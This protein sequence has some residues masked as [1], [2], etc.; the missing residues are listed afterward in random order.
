MQINDWPQFIAIVATFLATIGSLLYNILMER[1]GRV[2]NIVVSRR[3]ERIETIMKSSAHVMALAHPLVI[4]TKEQTF[5]VELMRHFEMAN[6]TLQNCKAIDIEIKAELKSV[7]EE[8][9]KY[10]KL[11]LCDDNLKVNVENANLHYSQIYA[12]KIETL[13]KLLNRWATVLWW[14]TQEEAIRGK[15]LNKKQVAKLYEKYDN[16]ILKTDGTI[17]EKNLE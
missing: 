10:A 13:N 6:M 8:A 5:P 15:K 1:K 17:M 4:K 12:V 7:V 2:S 11:C 3:F 14:W 9:V 16:E